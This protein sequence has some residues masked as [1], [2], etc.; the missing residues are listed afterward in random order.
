MFN[1]RTEAKF[2]AKEKDSSAKVTPWSYDMKGH[3]EKCVERF[4]EFAVE[5]RIFSLAG[6]NSGRRRSLDSS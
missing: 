4:F 3:A 1:G 6:G 2:Q 5:K